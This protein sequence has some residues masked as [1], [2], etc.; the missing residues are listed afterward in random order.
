MARPHGRGLDREPIVI[1]RRAHVITGLC[2][3]AAL[4]AALALPSRKAHAYT[5]VDEIPEDP[6]ERARAFDP[7]DST[8]TAQKARR[9]CR[10]AVFEKRMAEERRLAVASEQN[11]RDEWLQKWMASTQPS[12]VINPMAVELFLGQ[13][14][15]N[16]GAVFSWTVLRQLELAARLG[17]R[18]MSCASNAFSSTGGD[19]TRTIWNLGVRWF[20]LD[21]DFAPFVGTAFSSTSAALAINHADPMTGATSFLQGNGRAHSISGSAGLQLAVSYVRL[22]VEYLYEYVFYTGA[23]LND[24]Q[25]TPSEDLR[26]IWEDSLHQDRHGVRFQVGFAF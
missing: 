5:F 8:L 18:Q 1:A 4:A 24:M 16:Y 17:Q 2:A 12:R 7:R 25:K 14:I 10:L 19:C 20:L 11:A 9:A 26:L 15:A 6:C 21:R 3:A 22:S 13:G 23:N